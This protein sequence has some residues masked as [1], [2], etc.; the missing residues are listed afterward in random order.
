MDSQNNA[1]FD[2][3][4]FATLGLS[5]LSFNAECKAK[6]AKN[7]ATSPKGKKFIIM[8]AGSASE[9]KILTPSQSASPFLSPSP[10]FLKSKHYHHSMKSLLRAGDPSMTLSSPNMLLAPQLAHLVRTGS[11]IFSDAGA[12]R[13]FSDAPS[14]RSL[15]SIGMGST[16]GRRMVIRKVPNSPSELLSYINPPT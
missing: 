14:V 3:Q 5:E 8:P 4:S 12:T 7:A 11:Y 1:L 2:N 9:A 10:S 15:A 6:A 13:M 16:D